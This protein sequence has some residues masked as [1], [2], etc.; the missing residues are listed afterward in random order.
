MEVVF[1]VSHTK[2]KPICLLLE[3]DPAVTFYFITLEKIKI[4]KEGER[5]KGD[6]MWPKEEAT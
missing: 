1:A 6:E 3:A 4:K 2:S 5:E